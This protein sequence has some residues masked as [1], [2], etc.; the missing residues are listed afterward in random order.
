MFPIG[1]V[2]TL[3]FYGTE[4]VAK[5]ENGPEIE[6][7]FKEV[8]NFFD[9]DFVSSQPTLQVEI[10]DPSGINLTGEVGHQVELTIDGNVKKNMTEFFV[11]DADS[12]QK[13]KLEYTL[14]ALSGGNHQIKVECWD[15]LN[16]YSERL[17]TF[18]TSSG[19][20]LA[21]NDVVN[22]PNPFSRD[23]YFTFQ[24]V[25]AIGEA[26]VTI[27]IYTVNRQGRIQQDLLGRPGLGRRRHC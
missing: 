6:V 20:K 16:N 2:D 21:M 19:G 8:P 3:L 7:S 17:I 5:D 12:Y 11:Y 23:T 27:N 13:G 9:G 24:L 15:N 1:Y 10:A 14:P 18:R 4:K 25:S 22:F 26:D